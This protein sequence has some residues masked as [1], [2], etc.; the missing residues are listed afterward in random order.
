[1]TP[2]CRCYLLRDGEDLST[3]ALI[4][5]LGAA[6]GRRPRLVAVPPAWLEL[7]LRALGRGAL[8]DRLLRSLMV[9]DSRFRRDFGWRPPYTVD[10]GLAETAAPVPASS[11]S[12]ASRR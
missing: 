3:A 1:M 4:R 2:G 5:R 12:L 10:E 11:K 6:L 8:A 9:D 7:G